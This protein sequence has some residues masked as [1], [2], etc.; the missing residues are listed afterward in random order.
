MFS[1]T[2]HALHYN[3]LFP[4]SMKVLK[5]DVPLFCSHSALFRFPLQHL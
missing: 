3:F 4:N 5:E 1:K 2:E